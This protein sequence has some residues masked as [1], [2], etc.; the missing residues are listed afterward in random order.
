MDATET[1]ATLV[2][3]YGL[4]K[5]RNI[6]AF[7]IGAASSRLRAEYWRQIERDIEAIAATTEAT[8]EGSEQR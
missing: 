5:A 1:A 3:T 7:S 4:D 2:R 8:E 6:A